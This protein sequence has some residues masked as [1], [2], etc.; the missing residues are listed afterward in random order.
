MVPDL[1]CF[2]LRFFDFA[3]VGK[4]YAFSSNHISTSEFLSF[5]QASDGQYNALHGV[6]AV[7][8]G[9]LRHGRGYTTDTP[10]CLVLPALFR[11]CSSQI[12]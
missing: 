10:Q 1:L 2:D 7:N 6:V 5:P 9:Q 8:P 3:M 12:T 4:Q 11:Y